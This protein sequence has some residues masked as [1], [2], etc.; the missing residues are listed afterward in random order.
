MA[1]Y[2][3]AWVSGLVL[4]LIAGIG[5]CEARGM[6][7]AGGAGRT[8]GPVTVYVANEADD[9]VT[10]VRAAS[11]TAG[12]PIRVGPAPALIAISPDGQTAYV[13]GVG[14]LLPDAAAPVT[15]TPIRTA[16]NRPGRVITV[17]APENLGGVI[18]PAAIAITPDSRTVYVSCPGEVVPVRAGADTVSEP[19]RISSAGALAMAGDGRTVYVANSDGDTIT[20]ISTATEEPGQPIIVGQSPDAMAVTPDGTT[21]LVLTSTG[22]TGVTPVDVATNRAGKP[23]AIQGAY[24]LAVAPGGG[25]AYVLATPDSDS[26]QGFV[27]PVH[28]RASTKGNPIKVGLSPQQIAFT[29]DG[30]MAYVANYASGSVTPIRLAD[31]RAGPPIAAGKIPTGLAVSPDGKMVYVLDSNIFG[32]LGPGMPLKTPPFA[33]GQVIPIHVATNSAGRPIKVGRF[34]I[35]IAIAP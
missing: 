30:K 3:A 20:P 33:P 2:D 26:Q 9:T 15:L 6:P 24:A 12:R 28:I 32:G 18:A 14:S 16:T 4:L 21:V 22:V 25:T 11:N 23:V 5:G 7:F 1:R 35:A 31:G 17:C 27:V 13:V 29:P 10:P 19:I 34:P 8:A